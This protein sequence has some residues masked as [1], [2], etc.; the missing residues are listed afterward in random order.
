MNTNSLYL[1]GNFTREDVVEARNIAESELG[2]G[3]GLQTGTIGVGGG[4][5]ESDR[6]S[7]IVRQK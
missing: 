7:A 4:S 2:R 3:G 6:S 1:R 5:K